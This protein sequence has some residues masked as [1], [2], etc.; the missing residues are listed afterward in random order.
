MCTVCGCGTSKIEDG[1]THD[2]THD[3]D[4]SHDHGHHHHHHG[5][6]HFGENE[7]GVSV[8]GMDEKRL[9]AIEQDILGKNDHLAEHNRAHLKRTAFLFLIWFLHQAQ[10]K[11]HY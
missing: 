1:H 3:H 11:Q 7:A 5:D 4:H 6:I 10:V 9:I 8:P 2:H